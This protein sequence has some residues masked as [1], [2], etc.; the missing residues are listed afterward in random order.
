MPAD[1]AA[2]EMHRGSGPLPAANVAGTAPSMS[3]SGLPSVLAHRGGEL[4]PKPCVSPT[5][6]PRHLVLKLAQ[7]E[8]S[9]AIGQRH[10]VV[11]DALRF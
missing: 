10:K 3:K 5:A 7:G 8:P 2:R 4:S 6:C 9:L 11:C 1:K